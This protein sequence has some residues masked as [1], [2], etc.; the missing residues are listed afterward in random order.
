MRFTVLGSGSTGNAFLI[1]SETTNVL[2]DAGMSAR[3]IVRRMAAV[4]VDPADLDAIL[5]THEHSDHVG[6]LRVLLGSIKCPVYVSRETE[7][8]YYD[9][10]A[11]G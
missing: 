2:V 3:E 6:G 7:N 4:G 10:R 1:S 5:I 11:G 8:A 9:T